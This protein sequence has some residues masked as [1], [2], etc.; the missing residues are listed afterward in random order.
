MWIWPVMEN[1]EHCIIFGTLHN[2]W[3]SVSTSFQADMIKEEDKNKKKPKQNQV[4]DID[5]G[6]LPNVCFHWCIHL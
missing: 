6:K 2:D 5:I 3:K 4:F 1:L